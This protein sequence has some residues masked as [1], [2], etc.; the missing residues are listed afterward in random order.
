MLHQLPDITG[1]GT[2]P[3]Q[4]SATPIRCNWIRFQT[5]NSVHA[6]GS[7]VRVGDASVSATQ[8]LAVP[9]NG[10]EVLEPASA[11]NSYDLSQT[12]LNIANGDA[13]QVSYGQI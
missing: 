12:Y 2:N 8:G 1:T 6:N 5:S 7:V 9:P 13:V 3:V 11:T 10:D 4:L